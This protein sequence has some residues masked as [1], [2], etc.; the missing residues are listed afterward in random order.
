[1]LRNRSKLILVELITLWLSFLL[2][3]VLW[4]CFCCCVHRLH[5]LESPAQYCLNPTT[6]NWREGTKFKPLLDDPALV[7]LMYLNN[8]YENLLMLFLL[9]NKLF[10]AEGAVAVVDTG[11]LCVVDGWVATV[12]ARR[13]HNG[14]ERLQ[15]WAPQ[16]IQYIIHRS[17]MFCVWV[18]S[19]LLL[20]SFEWNTNIARCSL[21]VRI[22]FPFAFD[23]HSFEWPTRGIP[24]S[25]VLPFYGNI[26]KWNETVM[27]LI[28]D[29]GV[30]SR[31]NNILYSLKNQSRSN[32]EIYCNNSTHYSGPQESHI[33][34]Y[35][36]SC[37]RFIES[38][39]TVSACAFYDYIDYY[40][41]WGPQ[42]DRTSIASF[43]Q[44]RV[45]RARKDDSMQ[46]EMEM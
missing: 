8:Y 5:L 1:M 41:D 20:C 25:G 31:I 46:K 19:F 34:V 6:T 21:F 36:H 35:M 43:V 23:H 27:I 18:F 30:C 2:L 12:A 44:R 24:L 38:I 39:S 32:V 7:S 37:A 17:N 3:L 11:V 45:N 33:F 15:Q 42:V 26:Y 16:N 14:N 40:F 13:Q 9:T 10:I 28:E 4:T 29:R 22:V